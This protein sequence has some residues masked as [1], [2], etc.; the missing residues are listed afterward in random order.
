MQ[1]G[2]RVKDGKFG[3]LP[4]HL[5]GIISAN[6]KY[7]SSSKPRFCK[8]DRPFA[9][10]LKPSQELS[11]FRSSHV[12]INFISIKRMTIK[13]IRNVY[14]YHH[15]LHRHV[16]TYSRALLS[17]KWILKRLPSGRSTTSTRSIRREFIQTLKCAS[18]HL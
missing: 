18:F 7:A 16:E 17:V 1:A 5:I 14:D 8:I 11:T 3:S 13:I 12:M 10:T 15:L 4:P 9:D 6:S 2:C